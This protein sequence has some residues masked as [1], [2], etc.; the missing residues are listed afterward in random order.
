[1]Y[2]PFF[3]AVQQSDSTIRKQTLGIPVDNYLKAH[4]K[5]VCAA[6]L[7]TD[8]SWFVTA[9]ND[10]STT[11]GR[12]DGTG[13]PVTLTS[14]TSDPAR[15][16]CRSACTQ[17]G[18]HVAVSRNDV[19][20]VWLA[21]GS[22]PPVVYGHG[23][24]VGSLSFS[25]D[26]SRLLTTSYDGKVRIFSVNGGTQVEHLALEGGCQKM[27]LAA[28]SPDES[29]LVTA[30]CSVV[31]V[32]PSGNSRAARRVGKH[33]GFV[34]DL[35][36]SP[37]GSVFVTAGADGTRIWS[38]ASGTSPLRLPI[39]NGTR[40]PG[41][42]VK[43]AFSSDGSLL[44]IGYEERDV[45]IWPGSGRGVPVALPSFGRGIRTLQFSAEGG[46]SW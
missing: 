7:R 36:F 31:R 19:L 38:D 40:D 27:P 32:A 39:P 13:A 24:T 17:D 41:A 42:A 29:T 3:D 1:M 35:A 37:N 43:A 12:V 18:A 33:D 25:R 2:E 20:E 28:W 45:E 6:V 9:S 10:G 15:S 46:T 44:A 21:D 16:S 22:R 11:I 23:G 8:G 26:G 34:N 30:G 4:T 5:C 14:S